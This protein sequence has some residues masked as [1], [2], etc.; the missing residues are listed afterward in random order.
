MEDQVICTSSFHILNT[1]SKESIKYD[2]DIG[3]NKQH[4]EAF[5]KLFS[6][7]KPQRKSLVVQHFPI[8]TGIVVKQPLGNFIM[9]CFR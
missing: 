8:S 7:L 6:D 9:F 5:A 3:W 4:D 2:E 1:I